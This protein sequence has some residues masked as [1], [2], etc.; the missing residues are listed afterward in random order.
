M[1]LEFQNH[2]RNT[3]WIAPVYGDNGCGPSRFRKQGWWAVNVGQT[4]NI[5][6]VN[7]QQVNRFA[8]FYAQEF[9]NSGEGHLGRNRKPLVSNS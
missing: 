8:S 3:I 7:L 4:R 9:K 2:Y 6:D 5:W 1:A